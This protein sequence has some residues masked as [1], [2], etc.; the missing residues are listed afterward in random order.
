MFVARSTKSV[1]DEH[2]LALALAVVA[3]LVAY[4]WSVRGKT[5]EQVWTGLPEGVRVTFAA[6]ALFLI[7]SMPVQQQAFIYFQF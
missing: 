2:M 5:S 4:Q 6:A 1:V 7:F 3:G